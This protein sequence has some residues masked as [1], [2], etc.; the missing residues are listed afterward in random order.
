MLCVGVRISTVSPI[1]RIKNIYIYIYQQELILHN[2]SDDFVEE[3]S[4]YKY[5]ISD[6]TS[7]SPFKSESVFWR[8]LIN[9]KK[10]KIRAG[11]TEALKSGFPP[12]PQLNSL[13]FTYKMFSDIFCV[14]DSFDVTQTPSLAWKEMRPITHYIIGPVQ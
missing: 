11:Q 5:T 13:R 2:P 14:T 1:F 9:L 3:I 8:A 12:L 4:L 10:E 7:F 6:T